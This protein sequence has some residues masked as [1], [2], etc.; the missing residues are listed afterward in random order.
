MSQ[1]TQTAVPKGNT[2]EATEKA[3]TKRDEGLDEPILDPHIPVVDSHI[4]L[5]DG[6]PAPRYML[7]DYLTHANAGHRIVASV[8]VESHSFVR[9]EPPEVLRP[10]GEIEFANG[11]GAMAASGVYGDVRVCAAIVGGGDF[12]AGDQ[13]GEYLDRAIAAAPDRFRGIRQVTIEDPSGQF[14]HYMMMDRPREGILRHSNFRQGFRHLA[15]RGLSFDAC[16]IQHQIPEVVDLA[17]AFPTTTIVIDHMGIAMGLGQDEEGRLE[18]FRKWQENLRELSRRPNVVCKVGGL[19]LAQWGFGFERRPDPI[20]YLELAA[21][22]RP[23][24]ETAIDAFGPERCMMQSNFPPDG[25]SCGFVP[26]WNAL[27]HI[28]RN[29][30]LAEKTALFSGTAARVYRLNLPSLVA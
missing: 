13:M 7:E 11:V 26:L 23:Y 16:V 6:R 18:I 27:K 28:V 12:T 1:S 14:F 15:P 29:C 9:K 20:G 22:W 4:H 10:L 8:Y 3:I 25:R 17:D 21:T 19:G 24:V 30:S 5:F 2:A